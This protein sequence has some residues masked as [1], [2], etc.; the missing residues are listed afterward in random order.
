MCR[1]SHRIVLKTNRCK[2]TN[3]WKH[4][5]LNT[6]SSAFFFL[7]LVDLNC[8]FNIILNV[9]FHLTAFYCCSFQLSTYSTLVSKH[10]LYVFGD[11]RMLAVTKSPHTRKIPWLVI[12]FAR[13]PQFTSIQAFLCQSARLQVFFFFQT[14][15]FCVCFVHA[16]I[17]IAIAPPF[18]L[19]NRGLF[20]V[21]RDETR[22]NIALYAGTWR[23]TAKNA[24][25]HLHQSP[26]KTCKYT[27]TRLAD[28]KGARSRV[29][30]HVKRQVTHTWIGG[31]R[32]RRDCSRK[33]LLTLANQFFF[34]GDLFS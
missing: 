22:A 15:I 12:P 31:R 23:S 29:C 9:V 14:C 18:P 19:H 5:S 32:R 30:W 4:R 27:W 11:L 3:V 34:W 33:I 8:T 20:N 28:L 7:N 26:N 24:A 1:S 21:M 13:R 17:S 2:C 10:F 16:H 6:A 25:L